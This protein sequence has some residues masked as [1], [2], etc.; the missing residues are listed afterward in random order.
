MEIERWTIKTGYW[1][2]EA[3]FY[4]L[5]LKASR[6][7]PVAFFDITIFILYTNVYKNWEYNS[8]TGGSA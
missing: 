1:K 7:L 2:T 6:Q 4:C 8:F 3:D 5:Q